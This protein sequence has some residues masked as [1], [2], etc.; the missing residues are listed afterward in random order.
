MTEG[1]ASFWD[2]AYDHGDHVEHWESP[3]FPFELATVVAAGLVPAGATVL[4]VGCGGGRE[5]IFLARHGYPTI[6]IDTSVKALEIA[7]ARAVDAGVRVDFR[8]AGATDLPFADGS[9]GFAHD[10]GCLHV[11]DRDQR[12]AYARELHRVLRPGASFLLQGADADSDEEGVVAVD[13]EEIDRTFVAS[14]F[15]RGPVVPVA[16]FARSGALAG[17]LILLRRS[18]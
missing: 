12:R 9:I 5:A 6:G 18:G 8:H 10:R 15:S 1:I 3:H 14:A 16:L 7:R 13:A 17:N 4:D 11:I 2:L